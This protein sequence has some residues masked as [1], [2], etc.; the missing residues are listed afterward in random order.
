[1]DK[2]FALHL[3]RVRVTA[4]FNQNEPCGLNNSAAT[5]QGRTGT[6]LRLAKLVECVRY[7]ENVA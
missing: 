5:A 2:V 6:P 4:C 3:C 1:M 7:L